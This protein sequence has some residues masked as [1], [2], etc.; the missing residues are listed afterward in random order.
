MSNGYILICINTYYILTIYTNT[1]IYTNTLYT[2]TNTNTYIYTYIY[3]HIYT[4]IYS[5][6][7]PYRCD[8]NVSNSEGH[9][10]LHLACKNLTPGTPG[11]VE[12]L[13]LEGATQGLDKVGKSPKDLVKVKEVSTYILTYI[14]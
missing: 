6:I 4:Y 14:Y 3:I 5:Y 8:V 7:Y 13:L 1:Y 12:T 9:T 10:P 11:L 2:N